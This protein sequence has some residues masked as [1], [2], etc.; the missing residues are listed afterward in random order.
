MNDAGSP[1]SSAKLKDIAK[2]VGVSLTTVSLA[3]RNH[4]KI[5]EKRRK[6]IHEVARRLGYVPNA[7]AT[8]L[9]SQRTQPPAFEPTAELAWLNF[10]R[11]PEYLRSYKEFDLYWHG[12][13]DA[14]ARRGYR[15]VEFIGGR[16][17]PIHRIDRILRS[18]NIQGVLV[19]PHGGLTGPG[20]DWAAWD[21]SPYSI[22]RFGYS[23]RGFRACTVAGN[24]IQGTLLAFASMLKLGYQRIGYIC[25][26]DTYIRA[27]AGFM[28][29]QMDLPA[30]LH[31]PLL[32]LKPD[33]DGIDKARAMLADWL[34]RH[35]PEAIL[36]ELGE[37]RRM[38][39]GIGCRVPADI[40]LAATSVLDGNA[41]AGL[42]QHSRELGEAAVETLVSLMHTHHTGIP[43]L[44]RE[45]LV[46]FGWQD[47]D[48]LP[49]RTA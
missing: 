32:V 2:A 25:H 9:A 8:A 15:L 42:I 27:K 21:W 19:P 30:S 26:A 22:V 38:L 46:D 40:G 36:S 44:G 16:N 33:M 47:G 35:R 12:A 29:F 20:P 4:P 6:E 14:A 7:V 37:I 17:M 23:I 10:W 48:T 13:V 34:N 5:S 3:L 18:R 45:M 24:H 31:I 28:M 11:D 1:H 43:S 41:S 49:K 39:E